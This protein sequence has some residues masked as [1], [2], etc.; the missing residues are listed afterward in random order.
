[1]SLLNYSVVFV[2]HYSVVFVCLYKKCP[3][4][5]VIKFDKL[6]KRIKLIARAFGTSFIAIILF[7]YQSWNV[8][9]WAL[10]EEIKL[11]KQ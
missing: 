7:L 11:G 6:Q 3:R 4:N 2:L 8:V 10:D 1:M 5:F 9:Q